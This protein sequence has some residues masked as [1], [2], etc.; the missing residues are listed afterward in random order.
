MLTLLDGEDVQLTRQQMD[1]GNAQP[2]PA[3]VNAPR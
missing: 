1:A 3:T 2:I